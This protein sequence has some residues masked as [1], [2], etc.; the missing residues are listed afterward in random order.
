MFSFR[1]MDEGNGQPY[2]LSVLELLREASKS[3]GELVRKRASASMNCFGN[4]PTRT[5]TTSPATS[6]FAMWDQSDQHIQWVIAASAS[7]AVRHAAMDAA[8]HRFTLRNGILV[9]RQDPRT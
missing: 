1:S 2:M 8:I 5:S 7:V 9:I 6:P 3:Y 4:S